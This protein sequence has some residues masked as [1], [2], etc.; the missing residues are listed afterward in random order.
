MPHASF[1]G[2]DLAWLSH[3]NPSG[4]AS[5]AGDAA[6]ATLTATTGLLA[7]L[8]EVQAF[9]AA[10]ERESTTV[11]IDAPLIIENVGGQRACET[12]IGRAY[13]AR[14]ASCHTSNLT[15]YPDAASVRLARALVTSGYVHAGAG[16]L[17][18][19]VLEVYPHPALIELFALPLALKY[20]KGSAALRAAGL[21]RLQ[22]LI[23][24]LTD[25]EPRLLT[26]ALLSVLLSTQPSSLRGR[27]R[28]ELEDS[29]DAVVCAYIAYHH[30]Y[31]QG[32][33]T[34]IFGETRSGYIAVPLLHDAGS[35]AGSRDL[36]G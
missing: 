21:A 5:L 8:T 13:G 30:W 20:K 17:P 1:I 32:R 31:W 24:S 11:A 25:A 12:L 15:R 34:A 18:R 4:A 3:R 9:V 22:Q 28:K 29:L 35:A 6:G 26:N 10:H 27:A 14:H 7:S 33:R 23:G 2:I 19:V 36:V 16:R